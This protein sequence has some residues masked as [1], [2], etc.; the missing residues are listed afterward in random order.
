MLGL[1]FVSEIYL[2]SMT[3]R[4]NY[5]YKATHLARYQ[6][7]GLIEIKKKSNYVCYSVFYFMKKVYT[8]Q[9]IKKYSKLERYTPAV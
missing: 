6:S 9:K 1:G 5:L 8:Y 2:A 3:G 4:E 7:K